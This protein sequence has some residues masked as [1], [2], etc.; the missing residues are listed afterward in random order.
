MQKEARP[1]KEIRQ[2][3]ALYAFHLVYFIVNGANTFQ[4]KLYGELGMPDGQIGVLTSVP[5]LVALALMPLAGTLSDRLPRK[6]YLLAVGLL[7]VAASGLWAGQC[8]SFWPML[9]AVCAYTSFAMCIMP[10]ITAI[11]MEHCREIDRPYGPIRLLGTVGYQAGA[12]LV[13]AL[14]A[15]SLR[16]LY[17]LISVVALLS[18]GITF[19]MPNVAGHQRRE[20]RVPMRALFADRHVCWLLGLIL[21]ATVSSQFYMS[22]FAKHLGDLG[23]DNAT[24]AWITTL[25]VLPELPFLFFADRITRRTSIWNWLLIGMLINGV[26]WVALALC[27]DA[28]PIF[29]IQITAV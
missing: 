1:Q 13:G 24:V 2:Y 26:R 15:R 16:G 29:I 22:F 14:L 6:R 25:S 7:L 27:R 20:H 11:S 4:S 8:V 17:P 21:F 28:A 5:S 9:L 3:Y 23:M 12:L 18:F 19:A 10:V